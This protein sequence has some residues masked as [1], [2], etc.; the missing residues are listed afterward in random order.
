MDLGGLELTGGAL[1]AAAGPVDVGGF[2]MVLPDARARRPPVPR[3]D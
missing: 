1:R 3:A 2:V